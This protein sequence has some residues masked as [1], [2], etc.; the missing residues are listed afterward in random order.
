MLYKKSI[1]CQIHNIVF[2]YQLIYA[3]I[4]RSDTSYGTIKLS[5]TKY[6]ILKQKKIWFITQTKYN[7]LLL[8]LYICLT[9]CMIM[10]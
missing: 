6:I 9:L 5:T 10:F 4:H 7:I 2:Q 8:P 1:I 3:Y